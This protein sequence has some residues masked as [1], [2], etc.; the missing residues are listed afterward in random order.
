MSGSTQKKVNLESAPSA[1]VDWQRLPREIW[2]GM[3]EAEWQAMVVAKARSHG[4]TTYH[5][6][7]SRGS[8]AGFPDLV[9]ARVWENGYWA[10]MIHAE[11]KDADGVQSEEQKMWETLIRKTSGT[12]FLWRP[13]DWATVQ[14]VLEGTLTA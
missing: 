2:V 6:L 8:D 5:T 1:D 11:L 3:S 10:R 4:W 7:D 9:M 14:R 13:A 12:Y